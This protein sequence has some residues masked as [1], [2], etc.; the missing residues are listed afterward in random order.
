MPPLRD[1]LEDIEILAASFLDQTI[2]RMHSRPLVLTRENLQEGPLQF[3]L[4]ESAISGAREPTQTAGVSMR[5][6]R[7]EFERRRILE[8]LEKSCGKI[9]GP[10]GAAEL[11][12]MRPTTLSSKIA[13]LGIKR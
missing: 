9:Y 5:K 7:L 2:K 13:A 4:A 6:Q 12:G 8:A 11:L 1:H 3:R 10:D